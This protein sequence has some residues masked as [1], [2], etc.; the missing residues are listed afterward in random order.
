MYKYNI[1]YNPPPPPKLA[2][3]SFEKKTKRNSLS[4]PKTS[5]RRR[6]SIVKKEISTTEITKRRN[7]VKR[8][9]S[10]KKKPVQY[11]VSGIE[12]ENEVEI[13]NSSVRA[14]IQDGL[15]SMPATQEKRR[16]RGSISLSTP[17]EVAK[18][19]A[20]AATHI[21]KKKDGKSESESEIYDT[22]SQALAEEKGW[23]DND[24]GDKE[25]EEEK[26]SIAPLK[27]TAPT[28]STATAPPPP[29]PPLPPPPGG[30]AKEEQEEEEEK[31]KE[32]EEKRTCWLDMYDKE[33]IRLFL[34]DGETGTQDEKRGG[35]GKTPGALPD[36]LHSYYGVCGLALIGNEQDGVLPL[37]A[38]L[39]ISE[40]SRARLRV[41]QEKRGWL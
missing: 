40:R 3:A 8:R 7:S 21:G 17:E 9:P 10:L 20:E 24:D 19:A 34:L 2:I 23:G 4:S 39:S 29:P 22:A 11:M 13:E 30:A 28:L 26:D 18:I 16:G 15:Q 33:A 27:S 14:A 36:I 12:G 6:K 37:D 5:A 41:V 25:A 38:T 1:Y 35:F 32:K 31:E